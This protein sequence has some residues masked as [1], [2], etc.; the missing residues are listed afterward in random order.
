M[1]LDSNVLLRYG[2]E[3]E[4]LPAKVLETISRRAREAWVSVA[5]IWEL[6]IK[7]AA[8]RLDIP[9]GLLDDLE[10]HG[11]TPL[12]LGSEHALA[13]AELPTLHGDPFDRMLVA[14]ARL[15]GL[16]LVTTDR[17]L[18]AYDVPILDAA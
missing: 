3:P 1:L 11:F 9:D 12:T 14:Q 8:G 5:T 16:V 10:S 6:A 13:A 18:A 2:V 7:R 4:R 17:R 15:E